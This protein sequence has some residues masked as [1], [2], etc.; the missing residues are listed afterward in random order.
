MDAMQPTP[1]PIIQC[2]PPT[3]A[4]FLTVVVRAFNQAVAML[5]GDMAILVGTLVRIRSDYPMAAIVAV[6]DASLDGMPCSMWLVSRDGWTEVDTPAVS[7]AVLPG[8]H[9]QPLPA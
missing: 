8:K 7:T 5:S 1:L 6:P 3:D 9:D 2:T 4:G